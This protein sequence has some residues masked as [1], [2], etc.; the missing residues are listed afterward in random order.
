MVSPPAQINAWCPWIPIARGKRAFFFFFFCLFI[1]FSYY[2]I[3]LNVR[4]I[5]WPNGKADRE[6]P[7]RSSC[8]WLTPI[9][10]FP[11]IIHAHT[12]ITY[13]LRTSLH[14]QGC[15]HHRMLHQLKQIIRNIPNQINEKNINKRICWSLWLTELTSQSSLMI[16]SCTLL[17][18]NILQFHTSATTTHCWH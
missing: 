14:L 11:N 10:E 4:Y 1:L 12:T 8:N 5:A 9:I 6:L 7:V 13:M 16:T 2:R 18:R 3:A 17:E 15:V